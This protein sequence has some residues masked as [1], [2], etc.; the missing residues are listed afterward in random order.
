MKTP[1]W[2]TAVL[3]V[4]TLL[5]GA[6]FVMAGGTKLA[7]SES[8][9]AHFIRWGYPGWFLYLVG[10]LETAGAIGLLVPRLAGLSA[11][12]LG[13]VMVGAALTHLVHDELAAV[14]VPLVL[15]C[16]LGAIAYARR[17]SLSSL[18]AKLT[19]RYRS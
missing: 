19:G 7:A 2:E 17:D 3:W 10:F 15:L 16:F 18:L 6:F 12:L 14:P 4:L 1:V 5:L 13:G 11:L 9:S 8:Q